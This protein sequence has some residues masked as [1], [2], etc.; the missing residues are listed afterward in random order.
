MSTSDEV[1]IVLPHH[2]SF[3]ASFLVRVQSL[4]SVRGFPCVEDLSRTGNL[5]L[6]VLEDTRIVFVD[7]VDGGFVFVIDS[8]YGDTVS[9]YDNSFGRTLYISREGPSTGEQFENR[10]NACTFYAE[11]LKDRDVLVKA[12]VSWKKTSV[13]SVYNLETGG[14]VQSQDLYVIDFTRGPIVLSNDRGRPHHRFQQVPTSLV[15]HLSN[16]S[17]ATVWEGYSEEVAFSFLYEDIVNIEFLEDSQEG[18]VVV[19]NLC[20]DHQLHLFFDSNSIQH[21]SALLRGYMAY[22]LVHTGLVPAAFEQTGGNGLFG[23]STEEGG[24]SGALFGD[25]FEAEEGEQRGGTVH[26]RKLR[27]RVVGFNTP[28]RVPVDRSRYKSYQVN[29]GGRKVPDA[30]SKKDQEDDVLA[31]SPVR[32]AKKK[33][34][35]LLKSEEVLHVLLHGALRLKQRQRIGEPHMY[36][37]VEMNG[38]PL[39]KTSIVRGFSAP[40]WNQSF[41]IATTEEP[42][43][44]RF[45]IFDWDKFGTDGFHG[46]VEVTREDIGN[47]IGQHNLPF[48]LVPKVGEEH[49]YNENV[50]GRMFLGFTVTR[51][52][53]K[54]P[55]S[56]E[57]EEDVE[58]KGTPREERH[59]DPKPAAALSA[60]PTDTALAVFDASG[61]R[62]Q[63]A[64]SRRVRQSRATRPPEAYSVDEDADS[65]SAEQ[66]GAGQSSAL[67]SDRFDRLQASAA[68]QRFSRHFTRDLKDGKAVTMGPL[69]SVQRNTPKTGNGLNEKADDVDEDFDSSS[70]E[71]AG[72]EESTDLADERSDRLQASAASQRFARHF[73][74][75]PEDGRANNM[76]STRVANQVAQKGKSASGQEEVGGERAEASETPKPAKKRGFKAGR[77][78]SKI[79]RAAKSQN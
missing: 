57:G 34:I 52:V 21:V 23:G 44:L 43:T 48:K 73:K 49:K 36:C 31:F 54:V 18:G 12:L 17:L 10:P 32:Y 9:V 33:Q 50:G 26:D 47:C 76:G 16:A 25:P 79:L 65:L 69:E 3:E 28:G 6:L 74:R 14:S 63:S 46:Q 40:R 66:V 11:F 35:P 78:L 56:T 13:V 75:G 58:D 59:G 70:A 1:A 19:I 20:S 29:V 68:S 22:H 67:A 24:R 38:A 2:T 5:C 71:R 4:S 15:F 51:D 27:P 41:E 45:E 42:F 8:Q 72:A 62:S 39:G 60:T 30:S 55:E 37:T 7:P 77:F 61:R 53:N 64:A